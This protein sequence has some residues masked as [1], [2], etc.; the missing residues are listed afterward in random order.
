MPT[1]IASDRIN[2]DY[3]TANLQAV[4]ASE[5]F[6]ETW[7][8]RCEC[9]ERVGSC[10]GCAPAGSRAFRPIG[11]RGGSRQRGR[12]DRR[13][14]R[15]SPVPRRRFLGAGRG[16]HWRHPRAF[17]A[18]SYTSLQ[19][20]RWRIWRPPRGR[21]SPGRFFLPRPAA[22]EILAI[23]KEADVGLD[24]VEGGIARLYGRTDFDLHRF[25][26][27]AFHRHGGQ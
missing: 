26:Q 25:A 12:D 6:V 16:S 15:C 3:V 27:V 17:G 22:A 19:L 24:L 21:V 1:N 14:A 10:R 11:G 9:G 5:V 8:G 13:G 20:Q 18:G 7:G 23:A 2:S 4:D